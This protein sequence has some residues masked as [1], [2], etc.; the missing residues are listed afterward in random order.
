MSN[1]TSPQSGLTRRVIMMFFVSLLVLMAVFFIPAGTFA[2]WQGWLYLVVLFVPLIFVVSYLLKN[3]PD[4]LER[5]MHYRE[6]DK[7]QVLIIKLSYIPF[8]LAYILPGFDFRFGWSHM[9]VWLVILSDV[10]VL[11]SYLWVVN[12]FRTNRYASRVVE[13]DKGQSVI[14]TGPYALVRHPM[15]TGVAVMYLFS[16]LALGSYWAVIPALFI[17]P[18]LVY[19]LLSEEKILARDLPGYTDYMEKVK[20]HL[21]PGIW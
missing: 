18:I 12:V 14:S 10:L 4:L 13:V 3:E 1:L 8:I 2:F 21:F 11:A 17:L 6:Q 9:P 5:R 19:R 7:E 16:P 15:Y 20:Y